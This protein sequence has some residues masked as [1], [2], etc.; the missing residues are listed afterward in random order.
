M[1]GE[2]RRRGIKERGGDIGWWAITTKEEGT[3]TMS[4]TSSSRFE[5]QRGRTE[6]IAKNSKLCNT[7]LAEPMDRINPNL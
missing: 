2:V 5:L 6:T 3:I 4:P 7:R 1:R